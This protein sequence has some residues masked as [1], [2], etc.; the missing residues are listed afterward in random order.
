ML[1]GVGGGELKVCL[2]VCACTCVCALGGGGFETLV[3]S[4]VRA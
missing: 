2:D 3:G 4:S 1:A